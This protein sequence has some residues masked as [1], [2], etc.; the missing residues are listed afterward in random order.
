RKLEISYYA[1]ANLTNRYVRFTI[2]RYKLTDILRARFGLEATQEA[3]ES[4]LC[5]VVP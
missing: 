1:D 2:G 4:T 5:G 3:R